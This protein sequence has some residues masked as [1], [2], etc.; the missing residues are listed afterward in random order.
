MKT[1]KVYKRRPKAGKIVKLVLSLL[2]LNSLIAN[3]E[4]IL[5]PPITAENDLVNIDKIILESHPIFDESKVDSIYL[6]SLANWLHINTQPHVINNLLPFAENDKISKMQMIE[7]ER[8]LNQH[9]FVR[10][11]K[12]S[13]IDAGLVDNCTVS[14]K[15]TLKVDTWD[16]WSLVPSISFG[17]R[18]G[19][20]KYGFGFKEDNFLG[21]G[22]HAG[23]QYK[24]DHLRSGYTFAFSMPLNF[25]KQSSLELEFSDNDDGQKTYL[26]YSKPFYQQSTKQLHF[27]SSLKESRRD[28]IYQNG[29][30]AW[31]FSHD[32]EHTEL[33]YGHLI[34]HD[35]QGVL[36]LHLGIN[37]EENSFA[38][39]DSQILSVLPDDRSVTYPWVGLEYN[40]VDYNIFSNIRFID[41]REDINLGWQV[42][43]K[44]GMSPSSA[45]EGRGKGIHFEGE[46]SKGFKFQNTLVLLSASNKAYWQKQQPDHQQFSAEF[47]LHQYINPRWSAYVKA[48]WLSEKNQYLDSPLALGGE[49]GVRGY[50]N[51]YQHGEHLWST[52][53]ELRFNP[54][55]ELYQLVNVA[56]AAFV[57]SGKAWGD[58]KAANQTLSSI[59]SIGL[60]AR[61][62]S[63]HSSEG[64]V[65]H[66]DIIKPLNSAEN[67]DSW[68]WLVKVK[69]SL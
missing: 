47:E 67:I 31:Q 39:L 48:Q 66:M 4:T 42:M 18:A 29:E 8:I 24:K 36:R 43:T 45:K 30:I 35:E 6:H 62:F 32:I 16:T 17:R 10:E 13:F 34:S 44:V 2:F 3:A 58:T 51:Q 22:I 25:P 20:N 7:A 65:V 23:V 68:Q 9:S 1:T 55:W 14:T 41:H 26:S 63:S 21:L 59:S 11:S 5:C 60:G 27:V 33:A 38:E 53:A 64:N 61:L 69:K 15:N 37:Q 46:V 40:Q 56:W 50:S 19:N 12:V 52:S 28:S 54:H 57:D 49:S